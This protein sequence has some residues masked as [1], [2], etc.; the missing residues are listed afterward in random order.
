[1]KRLDKY[2]VQA[3]GFALIVIGILLFI[4]GLLAP[5]YTSSLAPCAYPGCPLP[6]YWW[7]P[8]A[9]FTSGIGLITA[10]IILLILARRMK[11]KPRTDPA[12]GS[13]EKMLSED[14]QLLPRLSSLDSALH[15]K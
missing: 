13:P 11:P 2:T 7:I 1:M 12:D 14:L 8:G 4:L 6:W 9:S 5:P 15:R 3:L 10:G